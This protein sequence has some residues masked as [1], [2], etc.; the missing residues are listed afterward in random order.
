MERKVVNS[1]LKEVIGE[2]GVMKVKEQTIWNNGK[3]FGSKIFYDVCLEH[4]E[5]DI[6]ASFDKLKDAK[7]WVKEN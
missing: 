7:N 1:E 6:V 4:G 5:G 2:Y 3:V